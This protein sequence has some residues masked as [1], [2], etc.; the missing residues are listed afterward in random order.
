M[1]DLE[2]DVHLLNLSK[3]TIW[4]PTTRIRTKIRW[5]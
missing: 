5:R 4:Y 3:S 2:S 1:S